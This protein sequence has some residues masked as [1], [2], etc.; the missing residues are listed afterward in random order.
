MTGSQSGGEHQISPAEVMWWCWGLTSRA[1]DLISLT[2]RAHYDLL[3]QTRQQLIF[4]LKDHPTFWSNSSTAR[5]QSSLL[6]ITVEVVSAACAA[7]APQLET[8]CTVLPDSHHDFLCDKEGGESQSH[9]IILRL[10]RHCQV[11]P[12]S[13]ESHPAGAS[14]TSPGQSSSHTQH[15]I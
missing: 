12:E 13:C 8:A 10:R 5:P 15:H 3:S 7:S 1:Q 4:F 14:L 6:R 9:T 2:G 11:C